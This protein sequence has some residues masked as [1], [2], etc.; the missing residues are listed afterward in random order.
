DDFV[1]HIDGYLCEIKDVQIRDGL[2]ILGRAPEGEELANDVLAIL[3]ARQVFGTEALPGLR[4]AL[5]VH[6]GQDEQELLNTDRTAIDRLEALARELVLGVQARN[7]SGEA[8]VV[9][10]VLGADVPDV[11]ATLR[12]ASTEVVP[13]LRRTT[14]E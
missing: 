3:R 14:D 1:L 9:T 2:H 11:T 10:E 6:F 5:A 7:W 12:F 4:A 13:R 8:E